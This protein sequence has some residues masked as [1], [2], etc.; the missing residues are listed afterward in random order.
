MGE[1]GLARTFLA[2]RG[3]R[4]ENGFEVAIL[5]H[6]LT[7]RL[8]ADALHA[9]HVVGGIADKREIV[10]HV[11]RRDAQAFRA[12]LHRDPLLFDAR[13]TA[14][15]R[16]EQPDPW[17]DQLLKILIARDDHHIRALRNGLLSERADD[18]VR[19]VALE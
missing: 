3:S 12:I 19:L 18:V 2:E 17:A 9:W 5:V 6:Q 13:G 10:R 16:I 1:Q 4:G 7:S 15:A 14:T 11:C 8:V